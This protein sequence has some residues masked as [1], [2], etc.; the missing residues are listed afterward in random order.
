[1]TDDDE[2]ARPPKASWETPDPDATTDLPAKEPTAES[3]PVSRPA[4][5]PPPPEQPR[6]PARSSS[7][8]IRP[9][10]ASWENPDP[11][12]SFEQ[13][14]DETGR[15]AAASS[16]PIDQGWDVT[17]SAIPQLDPSTEIPSTPAGTEVAA[18]QPATSS[19]AIASP[20]PSTASGSTVRSEDLLASYGPTDLRAAV[21]VTPAARRRPPTEPDEDEDLE[22]AGRGGR[23]KASFAIAGV[24]LLGL[25]VGAFVILGKVN[26]GRYV[27]ACHADEVVAEQGR[28]FPPW[29]TRAIDGAEWKPIKI[30][31]QAEC[32][33]R[34][35]EDEA[36]LSAW[37]LD[38]LIDR[39][40]TA[41]T[42]REVTKVDEANAMLEQALLHARAPDR[43]DKRKEIERLLGDVGYWRAAAK[44]KEASSALT[45]AAK[46]FDEAAAQRPRHVTDA[47]AWANYARRLVQDLRVGPAGAP[48]EEPQPTEH[49]GAP[50]GT[51]LP[52]EPDAG[53]ATPPPVDAGA[54]TPAD[55][56][57]PSGGVLL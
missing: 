37:Y 50:M 56:A 14:E 34:D 29:G 44:V 35:T 2:P 45:D 30:P 46:Q 20:I 55:A 52:V 48:S 40:S 4:W 15:T 54:A 17:S 39:A 27:I 38:T 32:R 42:A 51:A 49:G 18:P 41:L 19:S 21:G 10:R 5:Q 3:K 25:T 13:A 28:K 31:P 43:R 7:T 26:S 57:A 11:D 1:M 6:K 33:E 24:L 22:G 9:P 23:R 16:T 12:R 47:A 53:S 8:P 36:E